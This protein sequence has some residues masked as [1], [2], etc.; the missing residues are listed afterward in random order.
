M[1]SSWTGK[2]DK[3]EMEMEKWMRD[4]QQPQAHFVNGR[5]EGFWR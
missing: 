3:T 4:N 1:P 2:M 5:Y